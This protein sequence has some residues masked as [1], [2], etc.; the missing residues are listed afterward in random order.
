MSFPFSKKIFPQVLN[1]LNFIPIHQIRFGQYNCH[2]SS[3]LF[4]PG[5]SLNIDRQYISPDV[6]QQE[7]PLETGHFF[8]KESRKGTRFL[9]CFL[10][11]LHVS[12]PWKID[13]IASF[14]E[15]IQIGQSGLS[16]SSSNFCQ[17][18][19]VGKLVDERRLS[20]VG[21]ANESDHGF[22]IQERKIFRRG[23]GANKR[24]R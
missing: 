2:R 8:H 5:K 7:N 21:P 23:Q 18:M 4:Q 19:S 10:I 17:M 12:I 14:V 1:S 3:K 24:G 9:S 16:G 20:D 11:S 13:K 15:R 6:H 22:C